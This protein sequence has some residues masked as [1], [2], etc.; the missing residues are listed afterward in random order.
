MYLHVL[1]IYS[2]MNSSYTLIH[3]H[4]HCVYMYIYVHVALCITGIVYRD[5]YGVCILPIHLKIYFLQKVN[6]TFNKFTA[7]IMLKV[8][9]V[10]NISP[11]VQILPRC[12]FLFLSLN[13]RTQLNNCNTHTYGTWYLPRFHSELQTLSTNCYV[14]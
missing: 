1:Y 4:I 3:I 2:A 7:Q 11:F 14:N 12:S 10:P 6:F 9:C 13:S 8:I 5:C